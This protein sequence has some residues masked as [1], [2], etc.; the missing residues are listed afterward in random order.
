MAKIEVQGAAASDDPTKHAQSVIVS[1]SNS[2]V[3]E[4]ATMEMLNNPTNKGHATFKLYDGSDN[5]LV[6]AKA[7]SSDAGTFIILEAHLTPGDNGSTSSQI[8]WR[9]DEADLS[10]VYRMECTLSGDFDGG[11]LTATAGIDFKNEAFRAEPT[12]A[13][14]IIYSIPFK[15]VA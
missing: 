11:R 14:R 15:V 2:A 4:D 12:G 1:S 6:T 7:N 8:N 10:T 3:S 5:L 13:G 9:V